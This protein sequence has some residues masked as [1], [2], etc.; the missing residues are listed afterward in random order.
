MQNADLGIDSAVT[1]MPCI[2]LNVL[3]IAWSKT[4]MNKKYQHWLSISNIR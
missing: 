2:S 3:M 1:G 4:I